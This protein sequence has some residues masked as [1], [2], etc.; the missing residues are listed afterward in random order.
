VTLGSFLADREA[1]WE[2]LSRLLG[3]AHGRVGRLPVQDALALGRGYR[4]VVADLALA[5]RAYPGDPVVARLEALA[6]A[7]RQAVYA[8]RPRRRGELARFAADGY[9]RLV[10]GRPWLLAIAV[11]ATVVPCLLAAAWAL[12]A[13][14]A[15]L[16]LVPGE[17]KAAAHPHIHRLPGGATT[18]AALAGSIFTN[19]IQVAFLVF[20]GGLLLGLG[21]LAVLAYNGALLGA[22]A[23]LTIGSGNFA[24]FVRYI[25]PHGILE[26]S[27]FSVAGAA[28][29]R[30]AAALLDPGTR[31]R[32]EALR[33]AARP[34]VAQVLGTAVWLIVA[35]LTE[36]FVTPHGI[37]LA[38]ALAVGCG[39]GLLFWGLVAWR[40]RGPVTPAP[41]T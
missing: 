38:A 9:W 28:G 6:L 17:F 2:A 14:G 40:G 11:A 3:R 20:A 8:E 32:G 41:V 15:A 1:D 24:V 5:R 4:A 19:N 10:A 22:L 33:A 31:P 30:L 29:L 13:P 16:G 37:P 7:G 18:Q 39:L 23:G 36:G 21:T 25:V 34:A 35:G 12:H 27:C 26:L